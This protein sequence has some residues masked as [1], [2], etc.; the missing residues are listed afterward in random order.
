MKHVCAVVALALVMAALLLAAGCMQPAAPDT[1]AST[2]PT[3]ALTNKELAE[4][5]IA[6]AELQIWKADT[7]IGWFKGNA[8]TRNDSQI[9]AVITKRE[10]AVS[11]LLTAK[12][13]IASGNY[14]MARTRAQDAYAKANESYNDALR[15]ERELTPVCR[16]YFSRCI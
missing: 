5:A 16:G 2:T 8:S 14:T 11:Y 10:L 15:R 9:V 13:E 6:G 3:I 1:R 12:D 7:E 4:Q